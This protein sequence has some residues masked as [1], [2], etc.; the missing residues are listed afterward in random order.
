MNN[1]IVNVNTSL[2]F[3]LGIQ[4]ANSMNNWNWCF[5]RSILKL[6]KCF[7]LWHFFFLFILFFTSVVPEQSNDFAHVSANL[8]NTVNTGW[9]WWFKLNKPKYMWTFRPHKSARNPRYILSK[10]K[11]NITVC[12]PYEIH[13]VYSTVSTVLIACAGALHIMLLE[14]GWNTYAT[15]SY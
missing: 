1:V 15:D 4:R 2:I 10:M 9:K 12:T 11:N 3:N 5:Q 14:F 6:C 7:V 8:T 13:S